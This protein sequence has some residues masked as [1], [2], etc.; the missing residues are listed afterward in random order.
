MITALTNP[1]HA[2][3][4]LLT[5]MQAFQ[6]GDQ[7]AFDALWETVRRSIYY[8]AKKRGLAHEEA[9]DIAQK[10]LV[11]VY[12]YAARA[13]FTHVAQVWGWIRTITRNEVIKFQQK[14]RPDANGPELNENMPA[15]NGIDPIGHAAETEGVQDVGECISR[16]T[17]LAQQCLQGPLVDSLTFRQAAAACDLSLGKFKHRYEQALRQVRECMKAKGHVF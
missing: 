17:E 2:D 16:L 14:K 6:H 10:V 7:S 4:D 11:R 9:E 1:K 3:D 12:L 8:R 15:E 13:T 5:I